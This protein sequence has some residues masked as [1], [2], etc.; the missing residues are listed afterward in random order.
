[1]SRYSW[2]AFVSYHHIDR[3]FVHRLAERL[4]NDGLRV[5]FDQTDL[6]V[7]DSLVDVL[8][9]AVQKSRFFLVVMSPEYFAS[10][11]ATRE[12]ELAL[13]HELEDGAVK[14]IPLM[15]RDCMPPSFLA[16]KVWADFRNET[17]FDD[18]SR[19]LIAVL[20]D[21]RAK[22]VFPQKEK[23]KS[24]LLVGQVQQPLS[25]AARK[26]ITDTVRS[27]LAKETDRIVISPQSIAPINPN[28]CFVMM[29]FGSEELNI[30]YED[31]IRPTIENRCNLTCERGDDLFGS[32]SIMDD[33][34]KSIERARLIIAD[35][36][37]KNANVF[38]EV[39]IAHT[40]DKSVLLLAQ[41]MSDVP[42]DLRHRRVLLYDY[43]PRGCKKLERHLEENVQAMLQK[44][45][46]T[47]A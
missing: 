1:M 16:S 33:I 8:A 31:F 20:R 4:A 13:S 40:L 7:G 38:Y 26:E 45:Y 41:S 3:A 32:N 37:G 44:S 18:S 12:L 28:L 42:F 43:S 2:D 47:S 46:M 10:R 35:L 5:F 24:K 34:R 21:E 30:V 6:Q 14:V 22:N 15:R 25:D 23:Q 19:K 29:P 36:T 39:G 17:E 27:F 11:W 9:N